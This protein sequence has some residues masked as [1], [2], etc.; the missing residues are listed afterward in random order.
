LA[1]N[2]RQGLATRIATQVELRQKLE[3]ILESGAQP[4][5]PCVTRRVFA[6]HGTLKFTPAVM[7]SFLIKV[8][9]SPFTIA[10]LA[11]DL[12]WT[13]LWLK[14][15]GVHIG[16][17]CRFVGFPIIKIAPGAQIVLGAGVLVNSR[18]GSNSAGLPHPTILAATSP[19]SSIMIGEESGIS[20]ASIS[21]R[22][23]IRIGK[24][25]LIGAGACIWD[26]DFHPLKLEDRRENA[27]AHVH[28]LPIRIEDDVFIGARALILKGVTIGRGAVIGAGS[29]VCQDVQPE[30][31]VAGNP[32]K[33]I[34]SNESSKCI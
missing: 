16:R 30:T 22:L 34:G 24:R 6:N 1:D 17:R 19:E 23:G 21:A 26:N 28:A 18:N 32:A 9:R 10:V 15:L 3:R 33:V 13:P 4:V 27:N 31:V 20:G 5:D 8:A 2:W 14:L 25:V 11:Y 29:V 12:C 7:R